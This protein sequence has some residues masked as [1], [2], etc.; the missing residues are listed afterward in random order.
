MKNALFSFV[1]LLSFLLGGCGQRM[2]V[3]VG[4][5]QWLQCR[6]QP[7]NMESIKRCRDLAWRANAGT[8]VY[9]DGRLT[10]NPDAA[11]AKRNAQ[12]S[13]H[14]QLMHLNHAI[15]VDN[16]ENVALRSRLAASQSR[17]QQLNDQLSASRKRYEASYR[18]YQASTATPEEVAAERK[19]YCELER[20]IL[21]QFGDILSEVR[22]HENKPLVAKA[23][24][25]DK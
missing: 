23:T 11:L 22:C 2:A 24:E 5:G 18:K 3:Q 21:L 12:S 16:A 19:A 6:Y 20:N 13:A 4:P 10:L 14:S 15:D 1:F 9:V 25:E 17:E 8:G 7:R